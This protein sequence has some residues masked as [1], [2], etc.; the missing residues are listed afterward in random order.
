MDTNGVFKVQET[1]ENE[2]KYFRRREEKTVRGYSVIINHERGFINVRVTSRRI[3]TKRW[4]GGRLQ[5][6]LG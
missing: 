1:L 4:G 6:R 3:I 5:E 2:R